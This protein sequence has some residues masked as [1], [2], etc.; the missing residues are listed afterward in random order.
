[1]P[2]ISGVATTPV[3]AAM[4]ESDDDKGALLLTAVPAGA[5]PALVVVVGLVVDAVDVGVVGMAVVVVA[6]VVGVPDDVGAVDSG[7]VA[8]MA[9]VDDVLAIGVVAGVPDA[10]L[11]LCVTVPVVPAT[12]TLVRY[13]A[14]SASSRPS[15][16]MTSPR[17]RRKFA[18]GTLA[19]RRW[20][21]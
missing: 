20:S 21:A 8:G 7:V 5:T 11:E 15:S 18:L 1:M 12:R 4:V 3:G 13:T 17:P 9:V 19:S 6:V 16:A 2:P 14:F 10:P